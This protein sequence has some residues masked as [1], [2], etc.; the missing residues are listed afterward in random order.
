MTISSSELDLGVF[1]CIE[2]GWM[3]P[4]LPKRCVGPSRF[5]RVVGLAD[6]EVFLEL[7]CGARGIAIEGLPVAVEGAS[8]G[9]GGRASRAQCLEN[10][11]GGKRVESRRRIA[12]AQPVLA[13]N[14]ARSIDVGGHGPQRLA[15]GTGFQPF[16]SVRAEIEECFPRW[17][18]GGPTTDGVGIGHESHH[19]TTIG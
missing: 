4:A 2:L 19:D 15:I 13:G 17:L 12:D 14:T 1:G 6:R 16:S 3:G 9:L 18:P 8:D 5:H 11:L 10:S 7:L